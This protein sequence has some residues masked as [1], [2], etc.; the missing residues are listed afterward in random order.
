MK[1]SPPARV[2]PKHPDLDQLKRQAKELLDAVRA[3]EPD[4]L[5]EAAA[6][7]PGADPQKFALHDAQLVLARAYGFHSWPRLKAY[8]SGGMMKPPELESDRGRDVWDTI[9]AAAAGDTATLQRLIERDRNL[10]RAEYFYAPPILFAV[11]EGHAEAVRILLNAGAAEAEWNGCDLDGL[12]EIAR[13][14]N[15]EEVARLLDEVRRHRKPV[16]PAE[17]HPIH[18]AAENNDVETVRDL[19]NGDATLLH[20]RD[21]GGGTPLHGAVKG[22]AHEVIPLLLDRGADIDA[23]DGTGSQAL[24]LAVWGRSP[25][26]PANRDFHTARLLLARGAT[27]D[28]TIAAA[29]GDLDRVT[30]L[31]DQNPA[32]IREVRANG[33]RALSAAVK[34]GHREIARLLLDRGADPNWPKPTPARALPYMPLRAS[35]TARWW[36]C[37]WRTE[38]IPTAM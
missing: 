10:S 6:R 17:D 4:A 19:L 21:D 26:P 36:S 15:Y 8:L 16:A 33:R 23:T 12:I 25:L 7:Y 35:V 2:L 27:C 18:R 3:G 38:P 20:R 11:R 1:K 29:L 22:S 9:T 30:A 34:F 24:D 32:C 14:R 31:L 28:L 37:C 13:D 5:S